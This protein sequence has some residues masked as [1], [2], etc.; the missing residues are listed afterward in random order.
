MAAALVVLPCPTAR[1][2]AGKLSCRGRPPRKVKL[3]AE[4]REELYRRVRAATSSQREALRA[5][6][7][8]ACE[9]G[10]SAR[11]IAR[12]I[13]VHPRT[14]ERWRSRFLRGGLEGLQ[15]APRPGHK[16]KFG[17][18]SRLELIALA[19]EP[20]TVHEGRTRRTLEDLRQ[21]AISR[22][23]VQSISCSSVQRIL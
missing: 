1:G 23:I 16:P 2:S 11:Q 8:L 7:I 6:I 3:Q 13:G 5:R 9:Q 14:V 10:A 22:G 20:V 21:E 19:C 15:D 12:K 4:Q 17:P 18:V